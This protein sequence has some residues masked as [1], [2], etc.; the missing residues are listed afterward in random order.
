MWRLDPDT[1][2]PIRVAGDLVRLTGPSEILAARCRFR[3]RTLAG[4]LFLRTDLGQPVDDLLRKGVTPAE[5]ALLVRSTLRT[6]EGVASIDYVTP[7]AAPDADG[8]LAIDWQVTGDN[9]AIASGTERI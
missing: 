4:E 8:R 7:A 5:A 6:V 1:N 9:G 2:Q 3:L